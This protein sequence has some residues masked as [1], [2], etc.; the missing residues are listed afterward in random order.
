M[1][2]ISKTVLTGATAS[3]I[4][5]QTEGL[6]PERLRDLAV[7]LAKHPEL[8]VS[9]ITYD[10]GTQELEVLHTGPPR[11]SI[12]TIDRR[13]FTRQADPPPG[14]TL[15]IEQQS[16]LEDAADLIHITLADNAIL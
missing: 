11:H 1:I 7:M 9:V 2:S 14:W 4:R 13:R 5:E 10:D 15:S 16:D 3:E 12:Y 6:A 8:T